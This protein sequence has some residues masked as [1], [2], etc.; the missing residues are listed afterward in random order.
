MSTEVCR[1]CGRP[2]VETMQEFEAQWETHVE[3]CYPYVNFGAS[4][5]CAERTVERL[6]SQLTAYR[7]LAEA[8]EPFEKSARSAMPAMDTEFRIKAGRLATALAKVREM[9]PR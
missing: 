5:L 8:V 9:D 4:E 1:D 7:E 2:V 6:R 3:V